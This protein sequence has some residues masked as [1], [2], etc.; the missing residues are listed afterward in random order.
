M[1][2]SFGSGAQP[3][4]ARLVANTP[5]VA[6]PRHA[7]IARER[8]TLRIDGVE[9][10]LE[11][12]RQERHLGGSQAYWC[13]PRCGALRSHLYVCD[14]ALAC[15]CCH[16]LSYR[17]SSPAVIRAAKLRHRL[18]AVPGLLS[19]VPRKPRH[20]SPVAYARLV[21]ELA[22]QEAMIARLLGGIVRALERRKGRLHGPR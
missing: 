19:P 8:L 22:V 16:R 1:P 20:W 4:R 12:V 15:R 5:K 21:A 14:G 13:C 10:V 2:A 3:G 7:G 11:V 6:A 9:Q 17:R 18:G